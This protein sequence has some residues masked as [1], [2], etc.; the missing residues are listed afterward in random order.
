MSAVLLTYILSLF[1]AKLDLKLET[2]FGAQEGKGEII[3][4]LSS[5]LKTVAWQALRKVKVIV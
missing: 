1:P 2:G 5:R 4:L 3:V